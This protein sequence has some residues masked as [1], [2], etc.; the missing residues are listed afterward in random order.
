MKGMI[1]MS[2]IN[3]KITSPANDGLSVFINKF[4]DNITTDSN[5]IDLIETNIDTKEDSEV[6]YIKFLLY[7]KIIIKMQ[8]ESGSNAKYVLL[9]YSIDNGA[10]FINLNS[11]SSGA[12]INI[13]NNNIYEINYLLIENPLCCYLNMYQYSINYLYS[14]NSSSTLVNILSINK[15]DKVLITGGNY[16]IN[17]KLNDNPNFLCYNEATNYKLYNGL[18]YFN[19]PS[20][21]FYMPKII[22][23]SGDS[24]TRKYVFSCDDCMLD[25]NLV[26]K[27]SKLTINGSKYFS[28]SSNTLIQYE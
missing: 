15:N 28:L 23:T 26:E 8:Q 1:V 27:F 18:D 19:F 22:T 12:D 21:I 20:K 3:K 2:F 4:I 13:L 14:N 10:N 5:Y 16:S 9:Y 24:S 25:V 17:Y 11:S 6:W 7:G